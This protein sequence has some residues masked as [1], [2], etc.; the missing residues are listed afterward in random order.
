MSDLG[1]GVRS[2]VILEG[3]PI[4]VSVLN[5]LARQTY[6]QESFQST[7]IGQS[8]FEFLQ[9]T[10]SFLLRTSTRCQRFYQPL[11]V[12]AELELRLNLAA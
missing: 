9:R 3:L 6:W 5:L 2:Y 12:A 11:E 8:C 10:L 4:A 7:N 1:F